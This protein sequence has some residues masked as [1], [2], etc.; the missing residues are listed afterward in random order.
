MGGCIVFP[1]GYLKHAYEHF[2]AAAGLC[3]ADE[4]RRDLVE[5][6]CTNGD[7]EMQDLIPDIVTMAKGIGNACP[8]GGSDNSNN[9]AS[10]HEPASL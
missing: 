4:A 9:C 2:R 8:S 1:D 3:I 10:A 7:F 6:E 5:P